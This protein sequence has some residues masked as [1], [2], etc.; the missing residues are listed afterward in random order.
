MSIYLS[1]FIKITNLY[2]MVAHQKHLKLYMCVYMY[3]SMY[4]CKLFKD[5]LIC[6]S[7]VFE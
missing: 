5:L 4:V 1:G 3:V 2:K 6:V 7:Y